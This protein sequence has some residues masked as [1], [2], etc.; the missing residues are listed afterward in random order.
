[1]GR[2]PAID[3]V[4]HVEQ[5]SRYSD[6]LGSDVTRIRIDAGVHDLVL[7]APAGVRERVLA[8]LFRWCGASFPA[9]ADDREEI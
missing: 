9:R 1:M 8:E 4:P 3:A 5:L 2:S 6:A 7:S